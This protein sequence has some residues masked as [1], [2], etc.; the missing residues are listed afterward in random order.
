MVYHILYILYIC[1]KR[2]IST[3]KVAW[4][5]FQMNNVADITVIFR[6]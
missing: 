2:L 4:K 5:N 1:I 3:S 6:L